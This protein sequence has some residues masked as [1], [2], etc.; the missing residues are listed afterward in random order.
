MKPILV[1]ATNNAHKVEEVQAMVGEAFE[2][3]SLADIGCDV[4]VEE[5]GT[6]F[7]ANASI[8]SR[9]IHEHYGLNCF[10]DDSG[11]VVDALNGEPGVYSA[12]YS[13]QRDPQLNLELVLEKMA[14][15]Q[16]RSARF[17]SVISLIWNGEEYLFEGRVEGRITA[18]RSGTAGFGYDPIFIPEGYDQTFAEMPAE[19]KNRISHRGR[20]MQQ[21]VDFLK[22]Q[23]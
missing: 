7:V 13:G 9:Y 15:Q 4:D 8:K 21:M 2:L 20:A 3:K 10:A 1:F 12:R 11:L 5:I 16:D 14:G 19:E 18:E 23:S 17:V 22:N 6:T